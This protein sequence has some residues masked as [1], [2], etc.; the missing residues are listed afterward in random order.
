MEGEEKKMK[1]LQL[2]TSHVCIFLFVVLAVFNV[3]TSFR[4]PLSDFGNYYYGSDLLAFGSGNPDQLITVAPFNSYAQSHG[5]KNVFLNYATVTPQTTLFY[6][7]FAA[8][9]NPLLAKHLFNWL[10]ILAFVFSLF[11]FLD[12]FRVAISWKHIAL[13]AAAL[14]PLYYNILFGQ[15]Y[16]L[17]TALV[18][19]SILQSEKRPWLSGLFLAVAIALKVSPALLCLWFIAEKK[20]RAVAWT[21]CCWIV[22]SG[23]TLL[24]HPEMWNCMVA[25][26]TQSLPRISSGFISDP[27]SSSFQGFVVL[28]RKLM[29]PDAVLNPS[30]LIHGSER[31]VQLVNLIFY[32][33]VAVIAVGAWKRAVEWKQKILVL[34][35][36]LNI[37]SGYT[38]TYSLLLLLPFITPEHT[39]RGWIKALL[40]GI[41]FCLPPRLFDGASPFLEEY[42]L[43]IF[44]ALLIME[45]APAFSF[46]KLEKPQLVVAAF[47]FCMV[48]IKIAQRPEE[49]PLQYYRT[50]VIQQHYVLNAYPMN[51]RLLY[52]TYADGF[53]E[54]AVDI[55]P[56]W[57]T[58]QM[59]KENIN[60][61]NFVIIGTGK[62]DLLVL[63]DYHRGPG[64]LHLYTIHK[65]DYEALKRK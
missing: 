50:D 48:V 16:L 60:G 56:E 57:T 46:R 63:S 7:P 1:E 58:E 17:I 45:C 52:M 65:S 44:I 18:L 5:A 8:I 19:E 61:V 64:L 23:A 51:D 39:T 38:S 31:I 30:P 4:A 11:R 20:Y 29:L 25:F 3:Q 28:L 59:Y 6:I 24:L 22:I 35:L 33:C 47:F 26:Y 10:G 34:L 13:F 32:I 14:I 37:T 49:M 2:K 43:W 54:F 55:D 12:H 36:L 62:N 41:L 40:Y 21:I 9:V 27:Y 42:K 15:T 53:R